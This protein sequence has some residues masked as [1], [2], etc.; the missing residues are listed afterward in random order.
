VIQPGTELH[1]GDKRPAWQPASEAACGYEQSGTLSVLAITSELPWPLNTGGHLRSFHLLR[2]LSGQFR[3]RLVVPVEPG[4]QAAIA[5]LSSHGMAVHPVTVAPRRRWREA[6]RAA[7]A[8]VRAQPYA[9]YC[10]H[11]RWPVR[12][13]LR[14]LVKQRP[15]DVIYLDHLDSLVFRPLLPPA[16]VVMDLHNVYSTLAART[17]DEQTHWWTSLYLRRETRLLERMEQ[18]AARVADAL[19]TV[20]PDD[21]RYFGELGARAVHVVPNGVDC[22]AYAG[23][24]AGREGGPPTLLYIGAMSWRPNVSAVQFLAHHVLPQVRSGVPHARLRIVGRDP[25]PDV[26]AL[27]GLPGV[28]VLGSVPDVLPHLRQAHVLAVPLAAGG[29]TRLKILEAFA[30][31]LPVVATPVGCEGLPAVDGEHLVIAERERFAGAVLH[32]L[33][34]PA[35]G[36]R[37][38]GAARDLVREQFDWETVGAAARAAVTAAVR[39]SG[40]LH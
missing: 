22:A 16:P 6:L 5:A 12:A 24:P 1:R 15:P 27:N 10:R 37:L 25:G 20:S 17:A 3:V 30:A 13:A 4:Q 26:L 19:L 18:Q 39:V 31:G 36:K 2:A 23:L 8:A 38:A 40:G 33:A 9:F 14:T 7:G 28:E 29:G 11:D 34:D 35:L 21:G 32:L